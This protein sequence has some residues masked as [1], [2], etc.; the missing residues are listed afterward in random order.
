M[1]FS[2][3]LEEYLGQP[4][5][6]PWHLFIRTIRAKLFFNDPMVDC[7]QCGA[8]ERRDQD[9][10]WLSTI[11]STILLLHFGDSHA[12]ETSLDVLPW[13]K[14]TQSTCIRQIGCY[15]QKRSPG[16]YT[17]ARKDSNQECPAWYHVYRA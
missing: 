9:C 2:L 5:S 17:E 6:V 10:P 1:T 13:C 16:F 12:C 7:T 8:C 11:F 15:L 14:M 3:L 4:S